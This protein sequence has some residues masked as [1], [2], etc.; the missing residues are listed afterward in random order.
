MDSL[1][2]S[3]RIKEKNPKVFLTNPVTGTGEAG[4]ENEIRK[5]V[6][7]HRSVE[8]HD[9]NEEP[10]NVEENLIKVLFKKNVPV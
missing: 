3:K 1:L 7:L 6:E 2:D 8:P 9:L 4:I 5:E 10:K